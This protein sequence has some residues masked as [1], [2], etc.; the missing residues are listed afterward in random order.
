MYLHVYRNMLVF[1]WLVVSLV[2]CSY[3]FCS[4]WQFKYGPYCQIAMEQWASFHNEQWNIHAYLPL[5]RCCKNE[6]KSQ[7]PGMF[8]RMVGHQFNGIWSSGSIEPIPIQLPLTG[9]WTS[10]QHVFD[11]GNSFFLYKCTAQLSAKSNVDVLQNPGAIG[12]RKLIGSLFVGMFTRSFL[13][14]M[15]IDPCS[16]DQNL[17][18]AHNQREILPNHLQFDYQDWSFHIFGGRDLPQ[19]GRARYQP[20]A[21]R[22]DIIAVLH[23]W[24]I[25]GFENR[26]WSEIH[27]L[28]LTRS[29]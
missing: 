28:V 16:C 15:G 29:W 21:V 2:H 27:C 18:D 24:G 7:A 19:Q 11:L 23:Q 6:Q 1:R 4:E 22:H 12:I 9:R 13:G 26:C 8:S 14:A 5:P 20:P 25:P 10:Q 17:N 3:R